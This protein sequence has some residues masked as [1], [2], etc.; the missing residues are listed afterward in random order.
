MACRQRLRRAI[1]ERQIRWVASD[2]VG[3]ISN[4]PGT[5]GDDIRARFSLDRQTWG[6]QL[7]LV[8]SNKH[9]YWTG[10]GQR[11]C[12][13]RKKPSCYGKLPLSNLRVEMARK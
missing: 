9:R 13:P 6:D 8:E 12:G 10:Y 4:L 2:S 1:G 5:E 3:D 11:R 7:F